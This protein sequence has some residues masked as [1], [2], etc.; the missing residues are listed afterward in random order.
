M[1]VLDLLSCSRECTK[2]AVVM[3]HPKEN[4][5]FNWSRSKESLR[6]APK[7]RRARGRERE[8]EK[9]KGK[10]GEGDGQRRLANGTETDA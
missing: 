10:L 2:N 3:K 1:S 7:P 8:R 4:R 9:G 5:G 6:N